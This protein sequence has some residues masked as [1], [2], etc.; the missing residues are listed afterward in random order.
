VPRHCA[1]CGRSAQI[2]WTF[3][4]GYLSLAY[5][6]KLPFSSI[7]ID[8]GFVAQIEFDAQS[9]QSSARSSARHALNLRGIAESVKTPAQRDFL[10]SNHCDLQRGYLLANLAIAAYARWSSLALSPEFF[11]SD[12]STRRPL[13]SALPSEAPDR[14]FD[15]V[16]FRAHS[17]DPAQRSC[18]IV[19]CVRLRSF[20]PQAVG[21]IFAI[22]VQTRGRGSCNPRIDGRASMTRRPRERDSAS[23][24]RMSRPWRV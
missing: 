15:E 14:V 11:A 13:A 9:P 8:R 5:L 3:R 16:R 4:T 20:S 7:K 24:V 2:A 10:L 21:C 17:R 22:K 18:A 12:A 23:R 19:W 6:R 1:G